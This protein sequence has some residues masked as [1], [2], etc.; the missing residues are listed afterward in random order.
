VRAL[1]AGFG[2][3]QVVDKVLFEPFPQD[4]VNA[5]DSEGGATFGSSS[6]QALDTLGGDRRDCLRPGSS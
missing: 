2:V 4:L 3:A 1:I 6:S 5:L